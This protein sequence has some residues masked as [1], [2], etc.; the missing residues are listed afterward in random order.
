MRRILSIV[1]LLLLI[2]TSA[3]AKSIYVKVMSVYQQNTLFNVSYQLNELGYKM[4]VS[5]KNG[6]Y[7]IYSGPFEDRWSANRALRAIKKKIASNAYIVELSIHNNKVYV[8][9][10]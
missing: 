5:E 10:E 8:K 2:S 4:N 7:K 3:S 9:E 1:V 6:L